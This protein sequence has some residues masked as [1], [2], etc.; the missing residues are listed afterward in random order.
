MLTPALVTPMNESPLP[1]PRLKPFPMPPVSLPSMN[2]EDHAGP[3]PFEYALMEPVY[4]EPKFLG[5]PDTSSLGSSPERPST[6]PEYMST[7][8]VP[9]MVHPQP[10]YPLLA[11]SPIQDI[12]PPQPLTQAQPVAQA[13]PF[14][15][16]QPVTPPRPQPI[17]GQPLQR[18]Q[19]QPQGIFPQDMPQ[20]D[21][22]SIIDVGSEMQMQLPPGTSDVGPPTETPKSQAKGKKLSKKKPKA[23]QL[24]ATW[25]EFDE[26]SA[27]EPKV[28]E[29]VDSDD[30]DDNMEGST[31]VQQDAQDAQDA[32]DK[33]DAQVA[34]VEMV[35]Q[36]H[37]DM[38]PDRK[39]KKKE[40]RRG[41]TP[42]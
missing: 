30:K 15:Q 6:A 8:M 3:H 12:A 20:P 10:T 40:T 29:V 24:V 19:Q 7:Q 18:Q 38:E 14:A 34:E 1:L 17:P 32:Q 37:T 2:A 25:G 35:E 26:E 22:P 42:C 39:G 27:A 28:I 36:A 41:E 23:N 13:Q 21:T 4:E 33:L 11:P 9:V 5:L 31:E 16:P